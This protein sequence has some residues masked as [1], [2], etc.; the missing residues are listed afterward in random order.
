[1]NRKVSVLLIVSLLILSVDLP[2]QERRGAELVVTKNDGQVLKGELIAVKEN[3]VLL[4]SAEGADVSVDIKDIN[5]IIIKTGKKPKV[6][7]GFIIGLLAGA[8]TG[9]LL[10]QF[11]PWDDPDA[12][13]LAVPWGAAIFGAVGLLTG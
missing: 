4:L 8:A 5:M 10:G 13:E 9:A 7:K 2:S 11:L 12:R 3:S 6:E 1:M